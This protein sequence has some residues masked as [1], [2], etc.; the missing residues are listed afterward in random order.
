MNSPLISAG[1]ACGS[2]NSASPRAAFWFSRKSCSS[3]DV[4]RIFIS[5]GTARLSPILTSARIAAMR[6]LFARDLTGSSF[7]AALI[8]GSTAS[9]AFISPSTPAAMVARSKSSSV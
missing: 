7:S 6:A 1:I 2:R 4:V 8:S 9:G 3:A 5:V